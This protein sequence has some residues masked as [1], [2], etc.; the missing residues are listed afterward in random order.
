ML[1][2]FICE[3]R[4]I[5]KWWVKRLVTV[6][7]LIQEWN[8]VFWTI[9]FSYHYQFKVETKSKSVKAWE[10]SC[11][12]VPQKKAYSQC[13]VLARN[14]SPKKKYGISNPACTWLLPSPETP[15][16]TLGRDAL[17]VAELIELTDSWL[18]LRSR[19]VR[20]PALPTDLVIGLGVD[21]ADVF[22]T[23]WTGANKPYRGRQSK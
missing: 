23:L 19:L 5:V 7:Y 13:D 8:L 18:P 22:M 2:L 9:W 10:N 21:V 6:L 20:S 16:L 3:L 14:S 4:R 1:C 17:D 12:E 11:K 15:S